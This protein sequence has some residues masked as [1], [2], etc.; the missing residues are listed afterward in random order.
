M[1]SLSVLKK[2]RRLSRKGKLLVD[3]PSLDE[4]KEIIAALQSKTNKSKEVS[5]LQV[6]FMFEGMSRYLP[7]VY[8]IKKILSSKMFDPNKISSGLT[9]VK[10]VQVEQSILSWLRLCHLQ[11]LC[12][13]QGSLLHLHCLTSS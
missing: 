3:D 8:Y 5:H 13:G 10:S 12:T 9:H 1:A 11:Y 2:V 6:S 4:K 7:L